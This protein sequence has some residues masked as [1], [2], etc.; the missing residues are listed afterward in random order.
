MSLDLVNSTVVIA[1]GQFNPS[2]IREYWLIENGIMQPEDFRSGCVFT[3]MMVQ[4]KSR[5]FDLAVVPGQ[6]QISPHVPIEEQQQLIEEKAGEIVNKLPHTPFTAIGLNFHW[7]LI[8]DHKN[9]EAL[10]RSLFFVNQNPF[11]EAFDFED[12]RFGSYLSKDFNNFRM[13]LDVK[14]ALME[15][16]KEPFLHF[17]FN[18]HFDVPKEQSVDAIQNALRQWDIAREEST[19]ISAIAAEGDRP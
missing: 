8:P 11:Y 3:D 6:C 2:I 15:G 12:A 9:I 17:G 19:R 14:P 10:T 13:K 16:Q 4:V 7:H 18:F 1:A 5:Q